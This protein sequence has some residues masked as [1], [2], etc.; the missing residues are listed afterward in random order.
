MNYKTIFWRTV[1]ISS[2]IF[3]N[4]FL[5]I[6]GV[7]IAYKNTRLI[8]YGEYCDILSIEDENIIFFDYKIKMPDYLT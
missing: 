6:Y 7:C 2:I 4:I 5:L 8:A 1:K 3:L